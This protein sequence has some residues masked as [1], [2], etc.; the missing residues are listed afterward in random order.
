M[1]VLQHC[2]YSHS[3]SLKTSP[4]DTIPTANR[5]DPLINIGPRLKCPDEQMSALSHFLLGQSMAV[6]GIW[7]LALERKPTALSRHS[8]R[9]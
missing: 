7:S 5:V 2:E 6:V 4:L 1:Y 3:H 9:V 8:D